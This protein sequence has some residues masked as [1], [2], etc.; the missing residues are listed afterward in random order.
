MDDLIRAAQ[1][2]VTHARW[3]RYGQLIHVAN[4]W[5]EDLRDVLANLPD[6]E[7]LTDED[8]RD[9]GWHDYGRNMGAAVRGRE[10]VERLSRLG[11]DVVRRQEA[12]DA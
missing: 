11:F 10:M 7:P 8:Y 3:D 5:I 9:I 4:E 2:L 6:D 12:D 1:D